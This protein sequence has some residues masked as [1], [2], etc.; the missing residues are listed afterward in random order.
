MIFVTD[1]TENKTVTNEETFVMKVL[2]M[3]EH[4]EEIIKTKWRDMLNGSFI[5]AVSVTVAGVYFL[6]HH[7]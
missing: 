2:T 1:S 6:S 4:H 7:N 3:S 5:M